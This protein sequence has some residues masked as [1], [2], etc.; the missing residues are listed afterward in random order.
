M[1]S[2]FL[3]SQLEIPISHPLSPAFMRVFPHPPTHS[4]LPPTHSSTVGHQTFTG[5]RASSPI[6]ARQSHP[7]LHR[8]LEPWVPPCVLFGWRFSPWE[9]WGV[10]LVDSVVL[11]MVWQTPSAPSVFFSNSSMNVKTFEE[12]VDWNTQCS[13]CTLRT[14]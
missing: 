1:L 6:D 11:P 4:H 12:Y 5:P 9:L 3:V 7:L 14:Y 8:W 13:S 2:P 10:W